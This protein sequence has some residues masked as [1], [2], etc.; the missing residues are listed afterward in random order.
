MDS[1]RT[2]AKTLPRFTAWL[3]VV[4]AGALTTAAHAEQQTELL[5][6]EVTYTASMNKGVAIDGTATR[7]LSPR[8]DGTW[9]Y[10]TKVDSFIADIDESLVLRWQN[11]RVIP[12]RYRYRLSGF[13]IRDRKESINFDWESGKATGEYKNKDFTLDLEDGALDPLGLQLQ[14]SQDIKRGQ[15]DMTYRVIDGNRYDTDRFAIIDQEPLDTSNGSTLTLKAEKIREED[16]KRE[17]LMWFA[18][19]RDYLLIQLRQVE[20]DGSTYQLRL[21]QSEVGG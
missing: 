1:Y 13:L 18:P 11:N 16:S 6:Y 12:I 9:L 5:P 8:E 14:L 19:E 15:K 20:P 4:S 2:P 10:R 3:L 17:T 21:T 7:T